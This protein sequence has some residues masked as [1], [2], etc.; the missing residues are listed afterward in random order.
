MLQIQLKEFPVLATNRLILRQICEID[1]VEFYWLRNSDVVMQYIQ[2]PKFKEEEQAKQKIRDLINICEK[3]EGYHWAITLR[4]DPTLIGWILLKDIDLTNHRAEI[5]YLL[6]PDFWRKGIV[7]EAILAVIDFSFNTLQLHSLEAHVHPDNIASFKLLEK[8]G[9]VKEAHF[10]ENF[11]F[12]GNFL[13]TAVYSLLK[14]RYNSN[15]TH[16]A[17]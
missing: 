14:S 6:H 16:Y 9:F 13:D 3:N 15:K 5:G 12:E 8:V 7:Q 1:F 17:I 2:L 10:K 11:Y 4:K